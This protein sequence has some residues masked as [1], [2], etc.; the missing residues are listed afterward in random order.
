M[1][2]DEQAFETWL[3]AQPFV[4]ET[5]GG[6]KDLLLL[7]YLAGLAQGRQD[8]SG[9]IAALAETIQRRASEDSRET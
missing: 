5:H 2:A 6:L 1:T 8:A 7:A 4:P 3:K 9:M